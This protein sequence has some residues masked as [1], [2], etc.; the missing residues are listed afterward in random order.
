M[1]KWAKSDKNMFKFVKKSDEKLLKRCK[2]GLKWQKWVKRGNNGWKSGWN[3]QQSGTNKQLVGHTFQL[4]NK[5]TV[6][7]DASTSA[8]YHNTC[9]DISK[10]LSRSAHSLGFIGGPAKS[11]GCPG[12][13]ICTCKTHISQFII[14]WIW[15]LLVVN[16]VAFGQNQ[17]HFSL[18]SSRYAKLT[19]FIYTL[20]M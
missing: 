16:F 4:Q 10:S 7:Q 15:E 2:I 9:I 17:A 19:G 13:S 12:T 8:P 11:V 20:L 5:E 6:S 18:A 3:A 14:P 1:Q